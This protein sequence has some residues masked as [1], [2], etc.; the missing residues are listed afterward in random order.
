MYMKSLQMSTLPSTLSLT[1]ISLILKKDKHPLSSDLM[2]VIQT[3][4][5]AHNRLYKFVQAPG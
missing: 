1:H 5:S 2:N 4:E 3:N